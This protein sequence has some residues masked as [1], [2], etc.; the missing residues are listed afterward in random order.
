MLRTLFTRSLLLT[1]A[2]LVAGMT[3]S[4]GSA[5]ACTTADAGPT[6]PAT[7]NSADGGV[8]QMT[9]AARMSP[10]VGLGSAEGLK[11]RMRQQDT[12]L[13]AY[14]P[15]PSMTA[16]NSRAEAEPRG[17]T[18]R[19]SANTVAQRTPAL[20]AADDS[21]D[22]HAYKPIAMLAAALALMISIALRR[23]GK[24]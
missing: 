17:N 13:S 23:S 11:L 6:T 24:R 20:A 10:A 9:P 22:S 2:S 14:L 4:A 16:M 19:A 3:L 12:V 7:L 1:A 8:V 18:E 5:L 15:P 21:A